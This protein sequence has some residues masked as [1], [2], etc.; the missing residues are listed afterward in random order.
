MSELLHDLEWVSENFN[1]V[2]R[3][4]LNSY[5][6]KHPDV[7]TRYIRSDFANHDFSGHIPA[8][9]SS[10]GMFNQMKYRKPEHISMFSK[11]TL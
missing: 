11:R 4:I 3:Q 2:L 6:A 10:Y 9:V 7:N 8:M 1:Y 5:D